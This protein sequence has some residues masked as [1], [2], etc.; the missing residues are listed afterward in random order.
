MVAQVVRNKIWKLAGNKKMGVIWKILSKIRYLA[1]LAILA[2]FGVLTIP[3]TLFFRW[4]GFW[5]LLI[6]NHEGCSLAKAKQLL[7]EGTKYKIQ[8]DCDTDLKLQAPRSVEQI[9]S[10]LLP[11]NN[12]G[13]LE[14]YDRQQTHPSYSFL[15][16]NV[17]HNNRN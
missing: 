9:H 6:A 7:Q 1:C 5:I 8:Y 4:N 11:A 2:P 13:S 10:G 3:L 17:Y 16:Y 12:S 14:A 15:S